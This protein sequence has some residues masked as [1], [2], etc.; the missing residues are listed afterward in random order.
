M[1]CITDH[2]NSMLCTPPLN[3]EIQQTLFSMNPLKAIGPDGLHAL[4]FQNGWNVVGVDFCH[5]I[6]TLFVE[7]SRIASISDTWIALILKKGKVETTSDFHP[8]GLS[9][10][11]YKV[12]AKLIA[13]RLKPLLQKIISPLQNAFLPGRQIIDTVVVARELIH[14]MNRSNC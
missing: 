6:R 4:F 10:I 5:F 2:E 11:T 12:M 8:T 1:P 7:P 3:L 14:S 9:N 13:N